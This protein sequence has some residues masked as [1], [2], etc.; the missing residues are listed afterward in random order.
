MGIFA[1]RTFCRCRDRYAAMFN[2]EFLYSK[3]FDAWIFP[4]GPFRA[5]SQHAKSNAVVRGIEDR[6]GEPFT[7]LNC[8]FCGLDL[9]TPPED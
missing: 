2:G 9:P 1:A 3:W 4:N 6:S 5:M 7:W 8:P